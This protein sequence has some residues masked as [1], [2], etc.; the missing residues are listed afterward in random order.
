M[1][2]P[3]VQNRSPHTVHL[4]NISL[5]YRDRPP[6]WK[7]WLRHAWEFKRIP[8]RLGWVYSSLSNYEIPDGCPVAIEARNSHHV[9]VPESTLEEI[10]QRTGNTM[11]MAVAQDKLWNSVYSNVYEHSFPK[12]SVTGA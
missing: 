9:L 4:S 11:L 10:F 7:E 12:V 2:K 8:R 5:L 6:T 1:G 3:Q